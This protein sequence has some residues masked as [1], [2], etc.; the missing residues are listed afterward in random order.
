MGPITEGFISTAQ[1]L[2]HRARLLAGS[3]QQK[4]LGGG[5]KGTKRLRNLEGKRSLRPFFICALKFGGS[6]LQGVQ[7]QDLGAFP[8]KKSAALG[9]VRGA[10][11]GTEALRGG[12]QAQESPGCAW[13][14]P[15]GPF[16]N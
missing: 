9:A 4:L 12:G 15:P 7:H 11:R 10:E 2:C 13:W 5:E 8:Q 1:R 14:G 6:R 3:R 16:F